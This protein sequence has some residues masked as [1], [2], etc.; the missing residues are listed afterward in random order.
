MIP[1]EW[2]IAEFDVI[3]KNSGIYHLP[4]AS[5]NG[6][7]QLQLLFYIRLESESKFLFS[8]SNITHLSGRL[9]AGLQQKGERKF[10][11]EQAN[12]LVQSDA[13]NGEEHEL[14]VIVSVNETENTAIFLEESV[15]RWKCTPFNDL[16]C[17]GK[18]K[19]FKYNEFITSIP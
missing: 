7:Y 5:E 10:D 6:D 4:A 15:K 18:R 3:L 13:C 14:C 11:D 17:K 12:F 8:N 16:K 9:G 19:Y 2:F 1:G